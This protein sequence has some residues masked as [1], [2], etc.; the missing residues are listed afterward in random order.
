MGRATRA[1][2]VLAATTLGFAGT[3]AWLY[4]HPRETVI[5]VTEHAPAA[6]TAPRAPD[7]W[8]SAARTAS[9]PP[10]SAGV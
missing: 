5:T 7:P 8:T 1:T 4:T 2:W 6:Q 3:T 9:P 10:R